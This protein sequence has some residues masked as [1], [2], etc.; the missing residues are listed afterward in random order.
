MCAIHGERRKHELR[1]THLSVAEGHQA[2]EMRESCNGR[3]HWGAGVG[4]LRHERTHGALLRRLHSLV[5][6]PVT[7]LGVK[8][9]WHACVWTALTVGQ[10]PSC[11]NPNTYNEAE[12]EN[13]GMSSRANLLT[14]LVWLMM[15]ILAGAPLRS[16]QAAGNSCN[17]VIIRS[18]TWASSRWLAHQLKR[19]LAVRSGIE[20][21]IPI[22]TIR[23]LQ[24]GTC[25]RDTP[26][27]GRSLN[28]VQMS[29]LRCVSG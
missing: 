27:L 22:K 12:R 26:A 18:K 1:R 10:E 16:I 15:V 7:A 21:N 23:R 6:H 4:Q 13:G 29:V 9:Q 2:V 3:F 5:R 24:K 14:V 28:V 19:L 20:L 8:M 17:D 25:S 11:E